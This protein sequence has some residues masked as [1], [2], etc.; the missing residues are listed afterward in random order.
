MPERV[1]DE[2]AVVEG[3]ERQLFSASSLDALGLRVMFR[4]VPSDAGGPDYQDVLLVR[5]ERF[6]LSGDV[7]FHVRSSD[8]YTHGH[9]RDS[10]YDRVILHVVWLDDAAETRTSSGNRVPVLELGTDRVSAVSPGG[11]LEHPCVAAFARL[12]HVDLMDRV[13]AVGRERCVSLAARFESDLSAGDSNQVLYGG[14]LESLGYASNRA[15]FRS[16]AEAAPF[17]WLVTLAPDQRASALLDAAGLSEGQGVEPP[18]RLDPGGWRLTRLRP[19]N[20][21]TRRLAGIA[22]VLNRLGSHAAEELA[23]VVLAARRPSQIRDVVLA[24]P[25][26]GRG[27]SDEMVVSVVLPFVLAYTGD[28]RVLDLYAAYPPP[29]PTRWTRRM[30]GLFE[31]A[32]RGAKCRTAPDHQGLHALYH[33]YCR[34]E[35]KAG[36]P[37]CRV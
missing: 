33:S 25:H 14:L 16:L 20:H 18:A 9:H 17:A 3:W 19:A 34:F 30:Q 7:E 1:V 35:G 37:V 10:R 13:R 5:A 29:P 12:S 22:E 24:P 21:P 27:R 4:G 6:L 23:A 32:G 15:A 28:R 11:T 26:L 2:R 36:C 8:W 31:D